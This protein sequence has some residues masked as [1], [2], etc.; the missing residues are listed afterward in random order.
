[1]LRLTEGLDI[2]LPRLREIGEA[3]LK[4]NLARAREI[5]D[6]NFP[7][8][9]VA[10]VMTMMAQDVYTAE[11]LIPSIAEQAESV[12]QFLVDHDI[13]TIPSEVRALVTETPKFARWAT[14][15]MSTPGPFERNATEAYYDVTPVDPRWS[16]KEQR[17]W[18]ESFNRHVALNVTVHEA[19]PGH[20]VQ[21]LHSNRAQ[22]DIQK[23]FTSYAAVEGWAHYAEQMMVE[24]GFQADS[25]LYELGQIQDALL[26]NCRFLCAIGMHTEGMSVEAATSFFMENVFLG[27]LPSRLEAE[28][29]TF[30]P[31]YFKYTLGKLQILKLRED[32][33]KANGKTFSLRAF[34]DKLLSRGMPPVEVLRAYMLGPG[35]G[36]SLR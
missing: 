20:Y 24:E 29:G 33:R 21:F 17:E 30:D 31:G 25:P 7:G 36:P 1:M 18:L 10:D 15:M 2:P 4:R 22:T 12:R 13:I 23:A 11:T 26:R 19:Y 16:E 14:A 8:K 27:E 34:H 9:S 3:D 6:R 32:Y 28:R 35:A 5:V